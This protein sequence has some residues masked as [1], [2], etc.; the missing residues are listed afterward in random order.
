MND[1]FVLRKK[2]LLTQKTCKN[3]TQTF[4]ALQFAQEGIKFENQFFI[5]QIQF[6]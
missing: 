2:S 6:N 3:L 4:R 5:N 1:D